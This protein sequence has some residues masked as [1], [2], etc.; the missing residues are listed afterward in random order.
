LT[1]D[2]IFIHFVIIKGKVI[3]WDHGKVIHRNN[4]SLGEIIFMHKYNILYDHNS[5]YIT[6]EKDII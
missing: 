2:Y 4:A 1:F 3:F 6:L 5:V